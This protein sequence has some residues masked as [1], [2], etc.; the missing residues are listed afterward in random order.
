VGDDGAADNALWSDQL[1]QFV[2]DRALGIALAISLNVS[3]VADVTGL[4]STVA[5]SLAVR[6]D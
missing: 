2:L 4:G 6:I 3:E 5:V 1:D